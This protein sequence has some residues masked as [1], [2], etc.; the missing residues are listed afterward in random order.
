MLSYEHGIPVAV[1]WHDCGVDPPSLCVVPMNPTNFTDAGP[2]DH[3]DPVPEDAIFLRAC[4]VRPT[5][6][7]DELLVLRG[8]SRY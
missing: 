5:D 8:D 4:G 7:R 2:E 1:R 6:L 3:R